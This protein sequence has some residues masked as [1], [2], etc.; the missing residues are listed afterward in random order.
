MQS[1]LPSA[2]PLAA[3]TSS[4]ERYRFV[5]DTSVLVSAVFYGGTAEEVMRHV[6]VHHTLILSDFILEEC[7]RF[8][9]HTNPKT[10][11]KFIRLLRSKLEEYCYDYE[12]DE[13]IEIRDINDIDIVALARTY[14]AIILTSDNDL[15]AYKD[16]TPTTILSPADYR[17]LFL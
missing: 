10:P 12:P 6:V 9:K 4:N 5:I 14:K 11:Q 8:A 1:L 16:Q 17:E 2:E 15:L 7:I 3:G 13:T